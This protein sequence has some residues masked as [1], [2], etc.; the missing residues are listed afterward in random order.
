MGSSPLERRGE[1]LIF[2]QKSKAFLSKLKHSYGQHR[3]VTHLYGIPIFIF[4]YALDKSD[5]IIC[6]NLFQIYKQKNKKTCAFA[7]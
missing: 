2:G 3:C 6:E 1:V 4:Y 7:P 5:K